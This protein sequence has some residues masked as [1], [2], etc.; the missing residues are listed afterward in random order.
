VNGIR[1]TTSGNHTFLPRLFDHA[2][3]KKPWQVWMDAV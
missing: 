3:V 1:T 2:V